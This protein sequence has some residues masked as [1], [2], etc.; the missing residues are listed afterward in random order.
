[1]ESY[2][3]QQQQQDSWQVTLLAHAVNMSLRFVRKT[4]MSQSAES[5]RLTTPSTAN[6][7]SHF[8]VISF[9]K[10]LT[11]WRGQTSEREKCF[12]HEGTTTLF[13]FLDHTSNVLEYPTSWWQVNCYHLLGKDLLFISMY[14][15]S[16]C[17]IIYKLMEY[18]PLI[19][20][21]LWVLLCIMWYHTYSIFTTVSSTTVFLFLGIAF[22]IQWVTVLFVSITIH[23]KILMG[24]CAVSITIHR[25][26]LMGGCAVSI[27]IHRKVLMGGCAVSITIHRKVL[28]GGCAVSITFKRKLLMGGCAVSITIHRKVLMGGWPLALPSKEKSLWVKCFRSALPPTENSLRVTVLSVNITTH[29]KLLTGDSTFR[30]HYTHRKLLTGDST[31]CQHYT[32]RKFL[33]G[34]TVLSVSITTHRKFLMGDT[35]LSVSITTHRKF[36]IGDTV[37]SVSITTHRSFLMGDSDVCQHYHSQKIYCQDRKDIDDKNKRQTPIPQFFCAFCMHIQKQELRNIIQ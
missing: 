13:F 15:D 25:K 16:K 19:I 9:W 24:G 3:H 7:I 6:L 17:M 32:H 23:R 36:L 8:R 14:T 35:V 22:L 29:R 33:M 30:Q 11:H 34:D 28:M 31:F 20:Q 18:T 5:T 4:K 26:V 21:V 12:R 37:L 27:T 1:M 2:D 10:T